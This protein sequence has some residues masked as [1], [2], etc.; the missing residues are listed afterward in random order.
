MSKQAYVNYFGVQP[1]AGAIHGSDV[2][3]FQATANGDSLDY[4]VCRGYWLDIASWADFVA[5]RY[6]YGASGD[7]G[8]QALHWQLANELGYTGSRIGYHF[9]HAEAGIQ[10]NF[11]NFMNKT[12][13]D[14]DMLNAYMVDYEASP[15][16]GATF[17]KDYC[18]MVEQTRQKPVA[19][20]MGK[21]YAQAAGT[22]A[23][24]ASQL[25]I[26]Q[27]PPSYYEPWVI[28]GIPDMPNQYANELP[29]CWQWQSFTPEHGHLDL[30]IS[31]TP[32]L[33]GLSESDDFLSAL[34]D[35][36]VQEMYNRIMN[37]DLPATQY[38]RELYNSV[39]PADMSAL[40]LLRPIFNQ[41]GGDST[42]L[43][44]TVRGLKKS[45]ADLPDLTAKAVVAA[46]P[47]GNGVAV[48][49][50]KVRKIVN[51]ELAKLHISNS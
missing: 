35:A 10:A 43:I 20:Y 5:V 33:L 25:W 48:D 19:N 41:V 11:N 23:C 49:Y 14:K 22:I 21:Y 3:W 12:Y 16:A 50:D 7:D 15:N 31:T 6:S 38:I 24:P 26:A 40:A 42:E 30:N 32:S 36:Q 9:I 1:P 44:N 13:G 17:I 39:I 28:G 8:A 51:E 37:S 34:T 4:G 46:L 18:D 47:P 2:S 27:Y 45:V 29:G